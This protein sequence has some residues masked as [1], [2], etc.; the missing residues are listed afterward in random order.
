VQNNVYARHER[1]GR[2][3]GLRRACVLLFSVL[4]FLASLTDAASR[5]TARPIIDAALRA[6]RS[7]ASPSQRARA[8]IAVAKAYAS[9][10]LAEEAE[11][12]FSEAIAQARESRMPRRLLVEAGIA[13]ARAGLY[14]RARGIA[15]ELKGV[16][17]PVA[18]LSETIHAQLRAG[19]SEAAGETL[20]VAVE[21]LRRAA[22]PDA[23]VEGA[24]RL[25]GTPA[26][27]AFPEQLRGA[28]E[29]VL[30]R[31]RGARAQEHRD[32]LLQRVGDAY[33]TAGLFREAV[34]VAAEPASPDARAEALL[35]VADA[36][37]GAGEAEAALLALREATECVDALDVPWRRATALTRMA[38]TYSRVGRKDLAG[39]A[40]RRAQ[41]AGEAVSDRHRAAALRSSIVSGYLAAGDAAAA[42]RVAR[43]I[44]DPGRRSHQAIAI[45][46]HLAGLERYEQALR[47]LDLAE[48]PYI[49]FSGQDALDTLADAYC[50]AWGPEAALSE[51][52]RIEPVELRD[53]VL[54]HYAE[55][56]ATRGLYERA[57][58]LADAVKF[59]VT[60]SEALMAI[61]R[62]NLASAESAEA[63]GPARR[64]LDVIGHP[65]DRAR[66]HAELAARC[67]ELGL[68]A[69]A[70][71]EV[72]KLRQALEA[73]DVASARAELLT[74]M[75][76]TLGRL[77][78]DSEAGGAVGQAMDEAL[79][80]A[81]ASCRRDVIGELFDYLADSGAAS[82]AVAA[83]GELDEPEWAAEN[84]V[85]VYEKVR[86]Q[87]P[88]L[89]RRLL[90]AALAKAIGVRELDRRVE[91]MLRVAGLYEE[92]G[93]KVAEAELSVLRSM[94]E[95]RPAATGKP[96]PPAGGASGPA[97]LVYF[98]SAG[99][100]DCA[101]VKA[102]IERLRARMPWVAV[103]T[104]DLSA[105]GDGAVLNEAMCRALSVPEQQRMLTPA[106][107]SL[108]GALIGHEISEAALERLALEARGLPSPLTLVRRPEAVSTSKASVLR[109]YER[110][111]ALVVVSAGL[112][113]GINPCAFAV[114][115]FF[116]SYLTYLGHSRRQIAAVGIVFTAAVFVTYFAIG[117]GLS[118]LLSAAGA[119]SGMLRQILY[120]VT[121]CMVL[122]AAALSFRDGVRCLRGQTSGLALSLP[123]SLRSRIRLTISRRARLGLTLATTSV[124]GAVVAFFEFPCTGQIYVPIVF[125]L[126]S[127]PGKA[128]GAVGWLLLYNACFILPLAAVFLI[129]YLG[130]SFELLTQLFRRHMA[131]AK[132][133]MAALFAALF[134]LVVSYLV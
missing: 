22:A 12:A 74:R 106:V 63:M 51:L 128:W 35:S 45:A 76:V 100:P 6:A 33:A 16:A 60:R 112:V 53:A 17:G 94:P 90:Q 84:L 81:C 38:R 126:H 18:V 40:L 129:V 57:F 88:S 46:T 117:L 47:A 61:A 72:E 39:E 121:A 31:A 30:G 37:A 134:A 25:A 131:K 108:R 124:L 116:I 130:S 80:V 92:A 20:R 101:E 62:Q 73:I 54:K 65:I 86:P 96:R 119:W 11:R 99:C 5:P 70:L 7:C 75:A 115:I 110:L 26:A 82:L 118:G 23:A 15:A 19:L 41:Q 55:A 109:R 1:S 59:S 83:A 42:A 93:L 113:D 4:A 95:P 28:L 132:F 44:P 79:K 48:R 8:T 77:G 107:F 125:V 36:A 114:I 2:R 14:E 50:H 103:R 3:G 98:E 104:F 71:G 27:R 111:T 43:D 78:R 85:V 91:L 64:V 10:G 105:P 32:A 66:L 123:E 97:Y 13:C 67:A 34:R 120:V 21:A 9:A 89:R 102:A 52:L 49:A 24:V 133:A 122:V 127:M 29:L 68:A 56:C 69:E 58:Q 87:D